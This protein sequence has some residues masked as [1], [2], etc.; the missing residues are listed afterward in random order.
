MHIVKSGTDFREF[1]EIFIEFSFDK[2]RYTIRR[3]EITSDLLEDEEVAAIVTKY[4]GML[5]HIDF[6]NQV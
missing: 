3:H 6:L 4:L 5:I 2:P 1:S